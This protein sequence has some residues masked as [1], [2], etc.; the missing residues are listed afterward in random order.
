VL[1]VSDCV[2]ETYYIKHSHATGFLCILPTLWLSA[3]LI[4]YQILRVY[5]NLAVRPKF[6]VQSGKRE[7]SLKF[8][9]V[10]CFL[11]MRQ[12]PTIFVI[13]FIVE[14]RNRISEFSLPVRCLCT[15]L[16]YI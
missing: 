11:I 2:H 9:R 13:L 14:L 12:F 7:D 10:I 4:S 8:A 16:F 6:V 5:F 3:A 1:I 15:L